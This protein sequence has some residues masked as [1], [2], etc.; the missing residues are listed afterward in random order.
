MDPINKGPIA[1][2][3]NMPITNPTNTNDKGH[4]TTSKNTNY[5]QGISLNYKI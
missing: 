2:W 5:L 1:E 4:M 3:F